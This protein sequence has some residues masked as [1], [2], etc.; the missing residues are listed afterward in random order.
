MIRLIGDFMENFTI[1][2]VNLGSTSTKIGIY[3]NDNEVI[4][5]TLRHPKDRSQNR[6]DVLEEWLKKHEYHLS[7]FDCL[8]FRCGLIRPLEGGIYEL[9][10]VIVDEATSG[11]YGDHAVNLGMK[12][13]YEWSQQ[14]HIPAIVLDGPTTNELSDLAKVS[15][16]G[17]KERRSVFHALN[18]KR[19]IR[20]HCQQHHLDPYESNFV[21]AHLGGGITVSAH[22]NLKAIDVTNGVDGEGPFSPERTGYL[23]HDI[24]FEL[25]EEYGYDLKKLK[26]EL[27][28][29]GG[30][31]SYT[32]SND[33]KQ[34]TEDSKY[35]HII[36]AMIYQV[37]K[38]IGAMATV[39]NGQL[40]AILITGGIA[41]NKQLT[42]KLT[43]RIKW[44]SEVFVYPGE[45]ELK[46]LAEGAMRYLTKQEPIKRLEYEQ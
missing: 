40:D 29:Y 46:A 36:D 38:S 11:K 6:K 12:I 35:Q 44:I 26:H 22:Q 30:V 41:Y 14:Y 9:N 17:G 39:L 24:L 18:Q 42:D 43:D 33:I 15:G 28:K 2:A 34:L 8:S 20:Q 1:L 45:D 31:Y 3:H 13:G 7:Q 32:Q 23:S 4:G 37:S 10:E 21:V 5:E 16:F 19:T 27:Y 25:V